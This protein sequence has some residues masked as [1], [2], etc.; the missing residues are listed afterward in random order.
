MKKFMILVLAIMLAGTV[1]STIAMAA[2]E[3]EEPIIEVATVE[4]AEVQETVYD[5]GILPDSPFY[6]FKLFLEKLQLTFTFDQ[7]AKAQRLIEIAERRLTE[8][9]AL[10]EEKQAKYAERLTEAFVEALEE[11]DD[12]EREEE[13]AVSEA[14]YE[15]VYHSLEVLQ[16]VYINAPDQAKKGIQRAIHVKQAKLNGYKPGPNLNAPGRNKMKDKVKEPED[17]DLLETEELEVEDEVETEEVEDEVETEEVEDEVET[18]EVEDE[19]ETEEVE[20][21]VETEEVEEVEEIEEEGDDNKEPAGTM[22]RPT[23][24]GRRNR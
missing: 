11:V 6:F 22:G 5:A 9:A 24:P 3:T 20:D 15:G 13:D 14:V 8:L 2:P 19:V 23:A 17:E 10:P 4:E 18:E 7:E 16:S 1:F 21:E 12:L